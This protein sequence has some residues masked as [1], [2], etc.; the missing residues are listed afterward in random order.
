LL[1]LSLFLLSLPPLETDTGSLLNAITIDR[2]SLTLP[3][4]TPCPAAPLALLFADL[5]TRTVH[6]DVRTKNKPQELV[7]SL[8]RLYFS[9]LEGVKVGRQTTHF[10]M[11]EDT[12]A[13][14][15]VSQHEQETSSFTFTLKQSL[16]SDPSKTLNSFKVLVWFSSDLRNRSIARPRTSSPLLVLFSKTVLFLSFLFFCVQAYHYFGCAA[17]EGERPD[18]ADASKCT[19]ID[20]SV[21]QPGSY[22]FAPSGLSLRQLTNGL[23]G[24]GVGVFYLLK[25]LATVAV[26]NERKAVKAHAAA[27]SKHE[28]ERKLGREDGAREGKRR[29]ARNKK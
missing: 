7:D 18:W 23:A 4:N 17:V 10:A 26:T 20:S 13:K 8:I 5:A 9:A 16:A 27:W 1:V 28:Q 12:K 24:V 19:T 25:A 2:S 11:V 22:S 29:G 6:K 21:I 14:L 15:A 3:P